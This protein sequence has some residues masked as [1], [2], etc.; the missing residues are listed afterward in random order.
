M[1]KLGKNRCGVGSIV[2]VVVLL[3]MLVGSF[4]GGYVASSLMGSGFENPKHREIVNS[5]I[6]TNI[7]YQLDAKPKF[8]SSSQEVPLS[9]FEEGDPASVPFAYNTPYDFSEY[10]WKVK[11]DTNAYM[12]IYGAAEDGETYYIV[13]VSVSMHKLNV[14]TPIEIQGK[15]DHELT[16]EHPRFE[17]IMKLVD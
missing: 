13:I 17:F 16:V 3:V 5:I 14:A 10:V 1:K 7:P 6:V 9:V 2:A 12:K 8:I 4:V 11:G 15:I